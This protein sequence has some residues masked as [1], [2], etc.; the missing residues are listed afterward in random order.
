MARPA[1]S[2]DEAPKS[3]LDWHPIAGRV[4]D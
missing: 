3:A 4:E 1:G 2:A